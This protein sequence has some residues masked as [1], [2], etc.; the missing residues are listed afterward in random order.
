MLV[1]QRVTE[2]F[3]PGMGGEKLLGRAGA[4]SV[5]SLDLRICRALDLGA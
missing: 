1:Y 4:D 2:T 3:S 5:D